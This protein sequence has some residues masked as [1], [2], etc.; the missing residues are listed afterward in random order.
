M[1]AT[2]RKDIVNR[3]GTLT[4]ANIELAA[5]NGQLVAIAKK[6]EEENRELKSRLVRSQTRGP[7]ANPCEPEG[8]EANGAGGGGGHSGDKMIEVNGAGDPH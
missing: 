4:L 2:T 5:A 3:L 1:D 7:T 8:A 6:L